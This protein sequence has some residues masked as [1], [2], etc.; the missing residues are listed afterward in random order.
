[1]AAADEWATEGDVVV[2]ENEAELVE[3]PE[4]KLFNKW[5]LDDVQ[6]SDNSLTVS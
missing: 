6:V 4:I 3:G 1:M 2:M 5:S